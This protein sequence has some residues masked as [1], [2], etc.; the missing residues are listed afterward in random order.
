M[1]VLIS[2]L[3]NNDFV[4]LHMPTIWKQV[5][6]EATSDNFDIFQLSRYQT[7][8]VLYQSICLDRVLKYVLFLVTFKYPGI[9]LVQDCTDFYLGSLKNW[10]LAMRVLISVSVNND[11]VGLH[12]LTIC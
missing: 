1:R 7:W 10:V 5:F 6:S 8:S 2:V 3:V 4:G 12:M 9:K 11:F